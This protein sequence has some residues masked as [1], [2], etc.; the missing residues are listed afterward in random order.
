MIHFVYIKRMQA[1]VTQS[2]IFLPFRSWSALYKVEGH[3][4]GYYE[5]KLLFAKETIWENNGKLS[6]SSFTQ[7]TRLTNNE[8]QYASLKSF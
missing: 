2:Y 5:A 1:Y 3:R 8:M 4:V 7:E 6:L